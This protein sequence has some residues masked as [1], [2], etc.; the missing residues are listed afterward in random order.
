MRYL[1]YLTL[2]GLLSAIACSSPA[3]EVASS[4]TPRPRPL[5]PRSC[6]SAEVDPHFFVGQEIFITE[7]G[8]KPEQLI[9]ISGEKVTWINETDEPHRVR[10]VN[11]EFAPGGQMESPV[12]RPGGSTTYTPQGAW[13]IV[14][15]LGD[16]EKVKGAIQAEAYF[17][18]GEDPAAPNRFDADSP[19]PGCRGRQP[20]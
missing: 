11:L 4:P 13:S 12:I 15:Q 14:Y 8:F 19:E 2:L 5:Y 9:S 6:S 7:D 1:W 18:P 3:A 10:F 16:D 17:E 20:E